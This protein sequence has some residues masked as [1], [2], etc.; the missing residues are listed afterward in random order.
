MTI[1]RDCTQTKGEVQDFSPSRILVTQRLSRQGH[2]TIAHRFNGG[3]ESDQIRKS[4][5]GRKMFP[6]ATTIT[7][8]FQRRMPELC[9]GNSVEKPANICRPWRDS[10]NGRHH[11]PP[12][13]RWAILNRPCRDESQMVPLCPRHQWVKSPRWDFNVMLSRRESTLPG[14]NC[15]EVPDGETGRFASCQGVTTQCLRQ[16]LCHDKTQAGP[17]YTS[18]MNFIAGYWRVKY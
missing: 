8:E 15:K 12:L 1:I 5:Q 9:I 7:N 3:F 13:K 10:L 18:D 17:G 11:N 2:P 16:T 14:R 4:R 6:S